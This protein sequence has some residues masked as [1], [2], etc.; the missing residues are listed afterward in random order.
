M[1][2]LVTYGI[3]PPGFAS[4]A[5]SVPLKTF[6]L[7]LPLSVESVTMVTLGDRSVI[8]RSPQC[9]CVIPVTT[10]TLQ[11][12]VPNPTGTSIVDVAVPLSGIGTTVVLDGE[13]REMTLGALGRAA[14][15]RDHPSRDPVC[16]A[17]SS[18][19][20]SVQV[21]FGSSPMKAPSASSG[22]RGLAAT[23]FA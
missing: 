8:S 1:P 2:L 17:T 11:S 23:P 19:T 10:E 18:P 21:P 5:Q 13:K 14:M 9:G 6:D 7:L 16:P 12:R 22:A 20:R 4:S 3:W 15:E